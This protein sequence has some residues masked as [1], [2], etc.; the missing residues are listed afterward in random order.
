MHHCTSRL[1][2]K[3]SSLGRTDK[4]FTL[5]E[6][7]V[8]VVILGVLAAIAVPIYLNQQDGAKNSA[9]AA[10]LTQAKTA[11]AVAVAEGASMTAAVKKLT[12]GTLDTYSPSTDI[13]VDVTAKTKT[14]NGTAA[15]GTT[16]AV[17]ATFS[18]TGIWVGSTTHTYVITQ[19]TAAT[20]P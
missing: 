17:P 11:I 1:R 15:S 14:S 7:L 9:V 19:S 6:L 8:V 3:R 18:L 13:T 12:E 20:K 2:N 4:G 10:Q 5:I 16:A